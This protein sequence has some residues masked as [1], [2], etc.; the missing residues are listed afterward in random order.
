MRL[1]E[2]GV[3]KLIREKNSLRKVI[4]KA[5]HLESPTH[6]SEGLDEQEQEEAQE[7]VIVYRTLDGF[8]CVY[9]GEPVNLHEMLDVQLWAEEMDVQT[10]FIGL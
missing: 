9:H 5:L 6:A 1:M 2:R 3:M 7:W 8:C 10:W 4:V